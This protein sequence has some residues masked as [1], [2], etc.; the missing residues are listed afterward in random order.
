[1]D[2]PPAHRG[3]GHDLP[4]AGRDLPTHQT[5]TQD[6]SRTAI[7]GGRETCVKVYAAAQKILSAIHNV[8]LEE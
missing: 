2:C 3:P 4:G 8:P 1:M 7:D 6:W 5:P